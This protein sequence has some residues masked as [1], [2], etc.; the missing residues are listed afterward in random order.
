MKKI[1]SN[2]FVHL[3]ALA[4]IVIPHF[5]T[6]QTF[7][8]IT[9]N[10]TT[11]TVGDTFTLNLTAAPNSP[12]WA[13]AMHTYKGTTV[14]NDLTATQVASTDS[15]GKYSLTF[16]T[17]QTMAGY[18]S[19]VWSVGSDPITAPY[20]IVQFNILDTVQTPVSITLNKT[21]FVVG[22]TFTMTLTGAPNSPIWSKVTH[23][24]NG[25]T[26]QNDQTATQVAATD[27]TGKYTLTF[28]T[29]STMA[30][31]WSQ[32]WSVGSD[33]LTAPNTSI[34]FSVAASTAGTGGSGQLGGTG[35]CTDI[36]NYAYPS[37]ID[38]NTKL[39]LVLKDTT[40]KCWVINRYQDAIAM[41]KD[42]IPTNQNSCTN[43]GT[44]GMRDAI[45][46]IAV[47]KC[48]ALLRD[49]AV[50]NCSTLGIDPATIAQPYIDDYNNYVKSLNAWN[51]VGN[52]T[53]RYFL[54][55]TPSV[56][57]YAMGV[58]KTYFDPDAF[59]R[60]RDTGVFTQT[61]GVAPYCPVV[62]SVGGTTAGGG[63]STGTSGTGGSTG[64]TTGG[65]TGG[66]SSIGSFVTNLTNT[67][68]TA[69]LNSIYQPTQVV[70]QNA[71]NAFLGVPKGTTTV[72]P[73]IGTGCYEF[74]TDMSFGSTG[75]EVPNLITAL[76]ADGSLS[77]ASTP[78]SFDTSVKTAVIAFQEKYKAQILAPLGYSTGS[79][80]GFVGP[81][82]RAQLNTLCLV[83]T[84]SS[85]T[86]GSGSTTQTSTGYPRTVT[87][88]NN[89]LNVRTE[90]KLTAPIVGSLSANQKITV[91]GVVTGDL[92]GAYDQWWKTQDA[93]Y[94][95]AG[96]TQE[97]P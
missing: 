81:L 15:S 91:V 28:T 14:Q 79:G 3:C 50:P 52:T 35:P 25:T 33:P 63:G 90:P 5:V 24:Y 67:S 22:D 71:I 65:T 29:T 32:V 26:V 75:G 8:S 54:S 58:A 18:W 74:K 49:N 44:F 30:G 80:T 66:G 43:I 12:I 19:Q 40:I 84:T 93:N 64:G 96:G 82:T 94:V 55:P 13:K 51:Y 45:K 6:A 72:P 46:Q 42:L 27:A 59:Q 68:V 16:V 4:V 97:K 41:V 85:T 31:S 36:T 1:L 77:S 95:W 20:T 38:R 57:D 88:I 70:A 9:L 83:K 87:V 69:T 10:K 62:G 37:I 53:D 89:G 39:P 7:P 48:A 61:P 2:L 73:V 47:D 78:K 23:T 86:S 56:W 17:T 92:W 21:S 60:Y 11:F 34:Q 76:Q